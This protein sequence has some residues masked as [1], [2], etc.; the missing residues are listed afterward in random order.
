MQIPFNQI[1]V[2]PG[3]Q[4]ILHDLD[5]QDFEALLDEAGEHRAA[6]YAYHNR[7]LEIMSPLAEHEFNKSLIAGIIEI[8]LEEMD[9]E[10][11]ALG[12]TTLK[13][14]RAAQAVE[15]D[16]CFYVR[17]EAEVRGKARLDLNIDPP[18][19]LALEIDLTSRTHF[20]HYAALG[21]PELWRY[22]GQALEIL[23]LE[24]G[25]YRAADASD[26]FPQFDLKTLVPDIVEQAR[27][28][29]RNKVLKAFRQAVKCRVEGKA[30]A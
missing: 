28:E 23:L 26:L 18:P 6:R 11:I 20:R 7:E 3:H 30:V 8:M 16:E 1:I 22:D 2:H 17:H 4:V 29:G 19:D 15:P 24:D 12:S 13:N 27:Q 25:I 21:I 14:D 5:W 10:F 9:R